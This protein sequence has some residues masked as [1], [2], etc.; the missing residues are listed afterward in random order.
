MQDEIRKAIQ[1]VLA[2]LGIE[3]VD[4]VVEHPGDITHGDY[5]TNV[6]M[7][8]LHKWQKLHSKDES[9][10]G[11]QTFSNPREFAREI[12]EK[13]DNK[14]RFVTEITIAGAGFINF[15]L[16]RDFFREK[17]TSIVANPDTWGRNDSWKGKKVLVEY[18]DPNPFKEFHIGHVFTNSVGE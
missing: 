11:H 5:A 14:V 17:I 4:F 9:V 2:E 1:D 13:L 8:G 3:G 7:V 12:K 18:T 15:T 10:P 16:S 6:A